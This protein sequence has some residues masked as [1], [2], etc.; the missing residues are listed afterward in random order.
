MRRE[1]FKGIE[2]RFIKLFETEAAKL[3]ASFEDFSCR[4]NVIYPPESDPGFGCFSLQLSGLFKRGGLDVAD[5]L[6]LEIQGFDLGKQI[7]VESLISWGNPSGK[8]E[9]QVFDGPVPLTEGTLEIIQ[10]KLPEFFEKLQ[11]VI[12]LNVAAG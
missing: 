3:K 6:A 8:I 7:T 12:K 9:A 2:D 4:V 11:Q 5:N 10:N 1:K